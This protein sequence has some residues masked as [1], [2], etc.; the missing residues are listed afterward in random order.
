MMQMPARSV[1]S[2]FGAVDLGQ[3]EPPETCLA[4]TVVVVWAVTGLFFDYF[5]T[6]RL[7]INTAPCS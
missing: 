1:R 5:D 6:W 7:L 3:C 4:Y 2:S